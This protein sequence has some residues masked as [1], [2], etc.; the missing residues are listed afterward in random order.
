MIKIENQ[1]SVNFVDGND[2]F[3][4]YELMT[5]C[6]ENADYY[7]RPDLEETELL[8]YFFDTSKEPKVNNHVTIAG[9]I[10]Y[11]SI[12]IEMYCPHNS[13]K[14]AILTLHNTHNGYYSH[15]WTMGALIPAFKGHC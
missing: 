3:V 5:Q 11:S 2:V 15:G 8:C 9:D 6:C 10:E 13:K 12:E 14:R 4:G 1:Y 7:I